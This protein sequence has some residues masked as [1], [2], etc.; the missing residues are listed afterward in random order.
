M[1]NNSF[2]S[3]ILQAVTFVS[4]VLPLLV[5]GQSV[6]NHPDVFRIGT[7]G[8]LGTYFRVGSLIADGINAEQ[9]SATQTPAEGTPLVVAQRSNGSVANVRD[10]ADGLL[11]SALVQADVASL[12]YGSDSSELLNISQTDLMAVASLYLESVHLVVATD[13]GIERIAD[14]KGKRVSV[15]ELGSGT[16]LDVQFIFDAFE[17]S[18]ADIKPVYLKSGDAISRLRNGQ[19]DAF[20]IVA[21]Y[22]VSGITELIEEGVGKIVSIDGA[23][24]EKL[25]E[26][27]PF[28]TQSTIPENVYRNTES[29]NTLAVAALWVL[30]GSINES[31]AYQLTASLWSKDTQ[32]LLKSGHPKGLEITLDSALIGL[33]IP[34]HP[35]A[36]RYYESQNIDTSH[37]HAN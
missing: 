29:V 27:Y 32:N 15:D 16:Q 13:K 33:G 34:L 9:A 8:S 20:F 22:P 10:I 21:G 19:L 18:E 24:A 6:Q 25:S 23:G 11:E 37:L 31:V 36:A 35:G 12:A 26:R 2:S 17:I 28:F 5:F 7:G 14:L 4:V 30:D 3:Y 1:K